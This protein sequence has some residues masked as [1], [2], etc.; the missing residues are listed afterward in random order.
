MAI[1]IK[2]DD[3]IAAMR[4]AGGIVARVLRK[5]ATGVRPGMRTV[6]LDTIC[7]DELSKCGARSSFKGYR[8]F[9]A[10]ICTSVNDEVVHGIPGERMLLEGDVVSIDVGVIYDGFQGDA[11]ITVGVG[12]ISVEARRLLD[13]TEGALQAG[14]AAA[15]DNGH[16]GDISAAIQRHVEAEG[17]SVVREYT[18]HGIGR[19][20]HEEPQIPNFG[21]SGHGP[22]LRKGMTLA[23]EPMVNS[24]GWNTRVRDDHWT[25]VTA[26]GSLSA[27]FEH[28]IAVTNGEPEILTA[29]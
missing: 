13:V 6:D 19:E 12:E 21:M 8:G 15:K 14:I 22:R 28:T 4:K 29:V 1:R 9:P 23:I 2:S 17:F 16:L 20:M 27:H 18:G 25:V 24:G 11:A 26:D 10:H 7:V 5:L 3:D